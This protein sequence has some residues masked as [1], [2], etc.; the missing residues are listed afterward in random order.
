MVGR[1]K[2]STILS[3]F[4]PMIGYWI[5][6]YFI[7]VLEENFIF[8]STRLIKLFRIEL[9]EPA[10]D[11]VIH[12]TGYQFRTATTSEKKEHQNN[13]TTAATTD[14]SIDTSIPPPYATTQNT[15]YYNFNAWDS[16]NQQ[17][18]GYAACLAFCFGVA[19][20]V[21]GMNQVYYVCRFAA[22]VGEYN[23]DLGTFLAI[24]FSG[25][26]YPFFRYFELKRF[27]R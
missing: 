10:D 1:N 16:I 25:L 18:L 12:S 9:Y 6:I 27:G 23:A 13:E 15:P 14:T 20:V 21:L 4:L 26:V 5:S 22:L 11:E 8:R 3:N 2:F 7:L 19:G 24:G 17:T